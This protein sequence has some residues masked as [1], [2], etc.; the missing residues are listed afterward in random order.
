MAYIPVPRGIK[1]SFVFLLNGQ[2]VIVSLGLE[3][4]STVTPTDLSNV[5]NAGVDWFTGGGNA[6]FTTAL[7]LQRA[8]AY[9]LS[10]AT[11]P[12]TFVSSTGT[13]AVNQ[14]PLPNNVALVA[15]HRTAGRG[16]SSRGRQYWAG[17]PNNQ[18]SGVEAST[19]TVAGVAA[20]VADLFADLNASGYQPVV[21][22]RYT[23]NAP[24][25]TAILQP[26]TSTIVNKAYDSQ[27]RRLEGRGA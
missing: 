26:I 21:I 1:L 12:S 24:R 22:S 14:A 10:S 2:E 23:A 11:A 19:G 9:D 18:G 8:E 25:S 16:R 6:P 17:L 20:A 5:A 4:G 3:K 15:S 7:Q 27:R 13:G